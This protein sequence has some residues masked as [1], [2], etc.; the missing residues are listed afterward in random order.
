M[1]ENKLKIF[2]KVMDKG[3]KSAYSRKYPNE[4]SKTNISEMF[5]VKSGDLIAARNIEDGRDLLAG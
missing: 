1:S 5:Q 4:K 3:A 2:E